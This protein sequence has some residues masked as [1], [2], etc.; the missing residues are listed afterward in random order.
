MSPTLIALCWLLLAVV[1][2]V[3]A[4]VMLKYSR[5]FRRRVPALL[6]IVCVLAAFTALAQSVRHLDLAVAYALWGGFG[7][8]ATVTAGAVLFGQRLGGLG[9]L[10]I[11]V[12]LTGLALLK[13]G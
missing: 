13:F 1:L 5:G 3:V 6:S 12:L 7:I 2:D 11:V 8:L 10:G 4:N 9:V